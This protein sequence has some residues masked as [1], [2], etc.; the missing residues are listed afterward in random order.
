[1]LALQLAGIA[2]G[3]LIPLSAS[4]SYLLVR[5]T[6]RQSANP[7]SALRRR[8]G[9]ILVLALAAAFPAHAARDL[10]AL[11]LEQ[12][13][14]LKVVSA[15]KYEQKQSEVAAA[16]SIIT[17]DEIRAF[18][19]RTLAEALASLPG[20]HSTYDRQYSYLGARGFG[21]PGDLNT[22]LLLTIDG[23]RV[24]DPTFD[25]GPFGRDFPL[26]LDLIERIEFVPG[27]GGAVYGQNAMFGVVNVITRRGEDLNGTE[28][29]ISTQRPQ[30]L[31]EA[32]AS[33][34]KRLE[35]GV[36]VMFSLSGM[37]ARG[38]DRFFDF[39]AAGMSGMATGMDGERDRELFARVSGGPW[40]LDLVRGHNRK[41]DPTGAYRS[42]PLVPGQ[43]QG[44]S[45]ALTQLR[46]ED[47][48]AVDTVHVSARLFLGNARYRNMLSFGS[49]LSFPADSEWRGA[50]ARAL[51]TALP[52]HKVM[53]GLEVQDN[54]RSD[55]VADPATNLVVSRPGSRVG[56]FG[57]DEW[58]LTESL[59]ATLG[60]RVDRSSVASAK[61]SPRAALIWQATPATTFKALYGRAH[62]AP[63]A[64]ERDLED[65]LT[66]VANPTLKGES[67]D[68]FEL[69]ADHR[70]SPDLA[71]RASAY[72]WTMHDLITLGIDPASGLSQY[73]SGDRVK[74]RGLELSAD[75]TWTS[76]ARLRG[77]VSLQ[78]TVYAGGGALLNSP[79]VLGKLNLSAPLPWAGLLA[80]YELRYDSQRLSK[81]GSLGAYAV[82]N[83]HLSTNRLAKGL[84]VGLTIRNLFDKRYGQ[85][86]AD[87]NWQNA[88]EQDGRSIRL[89]TTYQF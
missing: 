13:M 59:T 44:D 15:S 61:S 37:R 66:Q 28:L 25:Q 16:V 14:G 82:S 46:Y 89:Q 4:I 18:G 33:W 45:Y 51:F 85:P 21:L 2:S 3:F 47:S 42:D 63:N 48:F 88:L 75:K 81:N 35:S 62:R 76:G 50:E 87:T 86:G 22:R 11:G 58:R 69:V 49:P 54:T 5:M 74:A 60:L 23:N 68:T 56:V 20:V 19:W 17:R 6:H 34:G 39:G 10:T 29:T 77:S 84:E 12:L 40:S 71:L 57:Q 7:D 80:G 9:A 83:L 72:Q 26:D 41:D 24:N 8:H 31:H 36:D 27:P 70:V 55:Q 64:F 32:R 79:S 53:L 38:E 67:M 52:G 78:D 1:M 65:G 73:Q 43:Y 30:G